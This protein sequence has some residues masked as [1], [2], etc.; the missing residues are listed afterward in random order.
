[1]SFSLTLRMVF[2]AL[3]YLEEGLG[4]KAAFA[5]SVRESGVQGRGASRLA[6]KIFMEVSKHRIRYDRLVEMVG[7]AGLA[8]PLRWIIYLFLYHAEGRGGVEDL[9]RFLEY[10]RRA[11]R[12]PSEV[13]GIFGLLESFKGEPEPLPDPLWEVEDLALD[14]SLPP[15]FV[16][17]CLKLLGRMDGLR[18]MRSLLGNLPTY[19]RINTLKGS[20]DSILRDLRGEGVEVEGVDLI[21]GVYR[22]EG[23]SKPLMGLDSWRKGFFSILDLLSCLAGHVADAKPYDRVLD[24]CAAP[25]GKTMLLAL[26]MD[27][28]GEIY[29]LDRSRERMRVWRGEMGRLGVT[30]AKPILSDARGRIPLRG[31]VDLVL[32]DPP[33]TG[34]G[35][36]M[37]NPS[38]KARL[39]PSA[40]RSYV[41]V[42]WSMLEAASEMVRDG[43]HLVYSTCSITREENEDLVWRLLRVD[44]RFELVDL[45]FKGLPRGL[46][47]SEC[48]RLYPHVN[49]CNGGFIAKLRRI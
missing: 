42:Q 5:R 7:G 29:S 37:K 32:L 12:I 34:T 48:I 46:F 14:F 33:C 49:A 16:G 27:N 41:G 35:I 18:F 20:E 45:G 22:V 39:S 1:M 31:E 47:L 3:R 23:A 26:M 8:P 36:L 9:C 10:A 30:I 13:E 40:L 2:D 24:L 21:P 38:M 15:W 28:K 44:P 43:G 6:L 25:G 19:I 11:Y 17:Y 4:E